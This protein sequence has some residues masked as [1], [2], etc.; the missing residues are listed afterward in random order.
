MVS[1]FRG[2]G[3]FRGRGPF[4]GRGPWAG[5]APWGFNLGGVAWTPASL[6]AASEVGAW[7]DPSDLSTMFTTHN[8]LT[9]ASVNGP[10][11]RIED[12]S[13]NGFHA[14]QSSDAARPTLRQAGSLYYLE[15]DGTDD[16]LVTSAVTPGT[17]KVQVFA[18]V[19]K[20]SGAAQGMIAELGNAGLNNGAF[21]LGSAIL[22]ATDYAFVSRGTAISGLYPTGFPAPIT[23]V[24]TG[25]GDIS[26]DSAILRANGAVAASN[27]IANQGDGNF[28]NYALYIGSR[29]G[30]SL[31]FN[32]RIYSMVVRFGANLDA[33]DIAS[34]ESYV[35]TKTGVVI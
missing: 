27:T 2:S 28:G 21:Y 25:L 23:N 17:N 4:L 26:G 8:G 16:S 3:P 20:L 22:E 19:R 1:P 35:A 18:G 32:G 30:T 24:L 10:V 7:Y 29:V 9:P 12:K 34:A 33:A 14:T 31:R 13:G 6:F 5:K 15:F 11:G